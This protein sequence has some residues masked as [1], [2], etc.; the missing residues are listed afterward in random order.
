MRSILVLLAAL[1]MAMSLYSNITTHHHHHQTTIKSSQPHADAFILS[2]EIELK[3]EI[4]E[5]DWVHL[6]LSWATVLL[7]P[8]TNA[9]NLKASVQHK[10]YINLIAN[11]SPRYLLINHL[12]I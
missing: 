3:E 4:E 9:E 10:R 8:N 1:I 2:E 5:S 11:S 6:L 7:Y 12:A